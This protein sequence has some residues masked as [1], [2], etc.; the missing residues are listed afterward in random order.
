MDLIFT[1]ATGAD[2]GVLFGFT[3]DLAFGNE[4]N[5]FELALSIDNKEIE[6]GA[7]IYIDGT[8]YGGIVDGLKVNTEQQ[9]V[10]YIGRTFHGI[11]NSKIIQPPAGAAYLNVSGEANEVLASLVS[12]LGLA[13]LFEVSAEASGI[14][15]SSYQ[16][17]RYIKGYDGINKMLKAHGAKLGLSFV[18][19]KIRL[20]AKPVVDYS[21]DGQYSSDHYSFDIQK[22][23]NK[24]NHLICLGS[25]ELTARQVVH[26][27]VQ[28][29]GS[30]ST[31]N[32]FFT[33]LDEIAEIYDYSAVESLEELEKGGRERLQ[34]LHNNDKAEMQLFDDETVLDINDI[35]GTTEE[36]TKTKITNS[37][38]K[39]I[40][41]I[42]DEAL[43]IEYKVGD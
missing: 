27:Y 11:L 28:E 23:N 16:M 32:E 42:Q 43:E 36:V 14:I 7:Y 33:G 17:D 35:V 29:D 10:T 9:L 26:L 3:L 4:E 24:V 39:K 6:S 19:G 31:E 38:V 30:I 2:V 40:V 13:D 37:V 41:K 25:G 21:Q 15:I 34:E 18:N 12:G 22:Y 1:D 20:E 8:E 5:D